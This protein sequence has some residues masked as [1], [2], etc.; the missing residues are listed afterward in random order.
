[1]SSSSDFAPKQLSIHATSKPVS[2]DCRSFPEGVQENV[3]EACTPP[4]VSHSLAEQCVRSAAS[5]GS[6]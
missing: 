4:Y 5:N 6:C 3:T 2:V 1:M